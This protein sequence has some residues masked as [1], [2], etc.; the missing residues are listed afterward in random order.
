MVPQSRRKPLANGKFGAVP[1]LHFDPH[2][3]VRCSRFAG[4]YVFCTLPNHAPDWDDLT[5]DQQ[6]K[7]NELLTNPA[8]A[9]DNER[10]SEVFQTYR[11]TKAAV[12]DAE[13]NA[14]MAEYIASRAEQFADAKKASEDSIEKAKQRYLTAGAL[15]Y[16]TIG[17][18]CVSE[19]LASQLEP[20]A[21]SLRYGWRARWAWRC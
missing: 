1:C 8:I 11:D 2:K 20:Q 16:V 7:F 9:Y 10:W 15:R 17:F 4:E 6:V 14:S 19:R 12:K 18:G 5:E 3:G 21:A 13:A